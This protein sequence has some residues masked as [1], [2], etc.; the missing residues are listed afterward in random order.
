[1]PRV[2]ASGGGYKGPQFPQA[3]PPAST[4]QLDPMQELNNRMEQVHNGFMEQEDKLRRKNM[5][6]DDFNQQMEGILGE[7]DKAMSKFKPL[8]QQISTMNDLVSK[9]QI[10]QDAAAKASWGLMVPA[11]AASAM[12]PGAGEEYDWEGAA[13]KATMKEAITSGEGLSFKARFSDSA[14]EKRAEFLDAVPWGGKRGWGDEDNP[15]SFQNILNEYKK[16]RA[17]MNYEGQTREVRKDLDADWDADVA[18]R[19]K[20]WD[21]NVGGPLSGPIL[22]SL[23]S[24]RRLATAKHRQSL[25]RGGEISSSIQFGLMQEMV[26][27]QQAP[28]REA[29]DTY[30]GSNDAD[31]QALAWAQQNPDDPR[32]QQILSLRGGN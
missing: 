6:H 29:P 14:V 31:R 25:K 2:I 3:T 16:Y 10:T 23:R 30:A 8:A 5:R 18:A 15:R 19:G 12:Y 22:K 17:A 4:E 20:S 13:Q 7:Y 24:D 11:G 32:A 1:M 9:G 26:K 21:W 27:K 28:P